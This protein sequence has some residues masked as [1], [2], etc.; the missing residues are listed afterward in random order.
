MSLLFQVLVQRD[1]TCSLFKNYPLVSVNDLDH[2]DNAHS[3]ENGPH[4]VMEGY[5]LFK[6]FHKPSG[7]M[8]NYCLNFFYNHLLL[9]LKKRTRNYCVCNENWN[10]GRVMELF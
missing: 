4:F 9:I 10:K 3:W 5:D 6:F 8:L 7:K 2:D 1:E